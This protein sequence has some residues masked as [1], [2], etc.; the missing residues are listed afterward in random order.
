LTAIGLET[1]PTTQRT[2]SSSTAAGRSISPAPQQ[3]ALSHRHRSRSLYLT[4]VYT[5]AQAID[6][7]SAAAG[8]GSTGSGY[9]GFMDNHHANRDR[10]LADFN[11][12]HRVVGSFVYDLP[13]G[14][15]KKFLSNTPRA[16][17]IALGNWQLNGIATFQKGFPYS[18]VA[19]ALVS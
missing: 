15:G 1:R 18:I 10:G 9:Q 14:R 16:V 4:G 12:D 3:V 17:D 7:K 6:T 11:V 19:D 13:F 2:S 8:I 5:W